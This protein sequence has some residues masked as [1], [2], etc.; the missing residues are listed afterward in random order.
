MLPRRY[1]CRQVSVGLSPILD[2]F[3]SSTTRSIIG[4]AWQTLRFR[5]RSQVSQTLCLS[6][7]L[8]MSSRIYLLL[9]P[10][11]HKPPPS[12][13]HRFNPRFCIQCCHFPIARYAKRLDV[14]LYPIS[15]LF[16]LPTP[17][18]PHCSFKPSRFFEHNSFWQPLAAHSDERLRPKR[19]FVRNV[20]SMLLQGLSRG[21]GCMR[22]S[23]GLVSCAAPQ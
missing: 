1:Y 9:S 6:L 11:G 20:V 8:A 10:R 18:S 3:D 4:V 15:P 12:L 2:S 22:S 13:H 19:F 23:G 5:V 14:P 16:L 17:S 7:L 21:C